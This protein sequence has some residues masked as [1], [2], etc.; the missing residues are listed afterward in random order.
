MSIYALDKPAVN[1]PKVKALG[2]IDQINQATKSGH[3][4]ALMCGFVL[5]GF[6]PLASYVLVHF[7]V[8]SMPLK[9]LIVA[10]AL[11]YSALTVF[12]WAKGWT[13]HPFK[14]FGFV[15]LLEGT[16]T[17]AATPW[18]SATALAL[19]LGIN[20]IASGCNLLADSRKGKQR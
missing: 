16:M 12:D 4:L 15:V 20:G 13:K 17:F 14:A 5:G 10:G 18:L 3:R 19:L 11:I 8:S 6:I 1:T 7:E 9:W 2:V